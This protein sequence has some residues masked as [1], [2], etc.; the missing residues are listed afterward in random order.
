MISGFKQRR[1]N[2]G[3][4]LSTKMKLDTVDTTEV[5]AKRESKERYGII[6]FGGGGKH[7]FSR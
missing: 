5:R 3:T 4:L 1:S 7:H 2:V 6:Y